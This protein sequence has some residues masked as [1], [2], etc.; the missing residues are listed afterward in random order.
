MQPGKVLICAPTGRDGP[1]LVRYLLRDGVQSLSFASLEILIEALDEHALA[2]II[3]EEALRPRAVERLFLVLK[4]QPAW[5]DI[6]LI[7]LTGGTEQDSQIS[8]GLVHVFGVH[9]N[10]TMLERP[11]RVPTLISAV[12]S[13]L[14][15]RNRQYEVRDLLKHRE[16][17][18]QVLREAREELERRV[19]ERTLEITKVNSDL[20]R[21]VTERLNAETSLRQLSQS[22]VRLQDEERRRIARDLHDSAGQ[23]LSAVTLTLGQLSRR[24]SQ[25]GDRNKQLVQ[26]ALDL[27]GACIKEVRTMSYLLHPPVLDDFGL[28]SALRWYVEGFSLRSGIA[29]RLDLADELPRFPSEIETALFRIVQEGLTNVHRHSGGLKARVELKATEQHISATIT[30]DG[31]GMTTEVLCNV[32]KGQG[33]VGLT[34]MYERVKKLGGQIHI[35][36][37]AL[38]T[39]ITAELPIHERRESSAASAN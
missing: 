28:A 18:E 11:I 4:N 9:G 5:S 21:E 3:A 7:L 27:V 2:V 23:Y 25:S 31:H 8:S 39:T 26:E 12:R 29:V 10:V 33:G 35:D 19:L 20:R 34:G 38:G 30:D 14:R 36:S 1:L 24:L 37:G 32:T 16:R 6:T 13:A 17:N 22:V 15:A